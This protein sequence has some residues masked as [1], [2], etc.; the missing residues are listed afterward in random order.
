MRCLHAVEAGDE[1]FVLIDHNLA[2]QPLP[3]PLLLK[4]DTAPAGFWNPGI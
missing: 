4:D 2:I 1:D 3:T